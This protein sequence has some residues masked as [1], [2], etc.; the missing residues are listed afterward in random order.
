M[1][2]YLKTIRKVIGGVFLLLFAAAPF[3]NAIRLGPQGGMRHLM[4]LN[5][6]VGLAT[7]LATG[8]LY[9]GLWLGAA[10][11]VLTLIFGRF[12]C[13]WMCP[14]GVTQDACS[15]AP[16]VNT[17]RA[18][19]ARNRYRRMYH[20]KYGLLVGLLVLA[21]LGPLQVGL[22]DPLA[23]FLRTV[24]G[25]L[26]PG[27]QHSGLP[28]GTVSR[29]TAGA[30][31]FGLLFVGILV[32]TRWIPRAWCRTVCPLGALLGVAARW[33]LFQ[34]RRD[35]KTCTDCGQCA[36][37]CNG[38]ADPHA[39][40]RPT[41][42][43]LCFNCV[44]VCP[45]D[46]LTYG[47]PAPARQQSP[48]SPDVS[49]RRALAAVAGGAIAFPLLR[50]AASSAN[51]PR[52][53]LIRPPGSLP[54]KE[55]LARCVKCS[56]CM[57]VCPTGGLQPALTQGGFETLWSPVLVPRIGHCEAACN[58]CGHQC[59]TGAI[60][61]LQRS[62]RTGGKSKKPVKI[63]T[64]FVDRG[65]CLPWAM[66]RACLVCEEVCPVSP[67]AIWVETVQTPKPGGGT[68]ALGRPRVE[69]QRCIG[70]GACENHCPVAG[71]AAIRVSSVGESRSQRNLLLLS[72]SAGKES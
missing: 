57:A 29:M 1:K 45:Q 13:S 28:V 61:P 71:R 56:A 36:A 53:A 16:R 9:S 60:R 19:R 62:D 26:V 39:L 38:A 47:R 67:K 37:V 18:R 43:V 70:C 40:L 12:F 25:I 4:E 20:L 59:P 46:A 31:V 5:P 42:C 10:L 23:L 54:E 49:R 69:P 66:G 24:S 68:L 35:Q 34:I 32:V 33:S 7:A 41:E 63:G 11:L 30:L 48:E 8:L 50:S 65:R 6:L 51:R 44:A 15:V 3:L 52:P 55:F 14:L 72:A 17:A 64:A 21:V 22:L 27:M 58:R 2:R